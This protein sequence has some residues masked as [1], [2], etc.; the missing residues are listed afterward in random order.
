MTNREWLNNL[1]NRAMAEK[2]LPPGCECEYCILNADCNHITGVC[3]NKLVEWLEQEHIEPMPK[4]NDG[5]ILRFKFGNSGE[6]YTASVVG[7]GYMYSPDSG[8]GLTTIDDNHH[9]IVE[10]WRFNG[11]RL[12]TIWRADNG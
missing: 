12:E 8:Y 5:D 3:I 9:R 4:L 7:E 11:K 6:V 10:V 2:I 1:N